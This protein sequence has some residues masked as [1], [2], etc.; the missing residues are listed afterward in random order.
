MHFIYILKNIKTK[1]LVIGCSEN[2]NETF[3]NNSNSVLVSIKF[4]K[5]KKDAVKL[6]K[7]LKSKRG[8]SEFKKKIARKNLG[9]LG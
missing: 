4:F 1:K 3:G 8:L 9:I 2:F 7:H 5:E 6:E